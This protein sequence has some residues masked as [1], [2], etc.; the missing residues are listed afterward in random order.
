MQAT[1][2]VAPGQVLGTVSLSLRKQV[3]SQIRD[4]VSDLSLIND[5]QNVEA[6]NSSQA[7]AAHV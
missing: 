5:Y 1:L 6:P 7:V 3:F 2:T 4:L